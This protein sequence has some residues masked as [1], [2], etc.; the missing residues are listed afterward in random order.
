MTT[1]NSPD[2][3]QQM[4][5]RGA[6]DE[7]R[8]HGGEVPAVHQ[9]VDHRRGSHECRA[10]ENER[11]SAHRHER[12]HD[13]CHHGDADKP[14]A[15]HEP[16]PSTQQRRPDQPC[17][18]RIS[19][20][21]GVTVDSP[22][23]RRCGEGPGFLPMASTARHPTSVSRLTARATSA[24][25]RPVVQLHDRI[26]GQIHRPRGCV[27]VHLRCQ[28]ELDAVDTGRP[29]PARPPRPEPA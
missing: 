18:D 15:A 21:T 1:S 11:P 19:L 23:V 27:P 29:G 13:K 26:A 25:R 3:A 9:Q 10:A 5:G 12:I 20:P 7:L 2:M 4:G 28:P 6:R 22:R 8:R 16:R 14:R 24:R 17:P